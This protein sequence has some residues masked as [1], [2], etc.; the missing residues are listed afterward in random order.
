MIISKNGAGLVVLVLSLFGL[1]VGEGS[2]TEVLGA[3]GTIVSFALMVWNQA[4]RPDV[5]GFFFKKKV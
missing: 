4:Y 1:E 5:E 2:V 3:I